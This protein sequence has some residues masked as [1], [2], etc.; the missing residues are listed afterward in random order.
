MRDAISGQKI[1]A[2][3]SKNNEGGRWIHGL[4]FYY[5]LASMEKSKVKGGLIMEWEITSKGGAFFGVYTGENAKEAFI[6]M[7]CQSGDQNHYGESH[8]GTENDWHITQRGAA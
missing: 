3:G 7:L 6:N 8:I 1:R 4:R 2:M 5:R